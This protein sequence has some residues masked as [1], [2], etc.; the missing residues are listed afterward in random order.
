MPD[1]ASSRQDRLQLADVA[2]D[3]RL[4]EAAAQLAQARNSGGIRTIPVPAANGQPPIIMR[5]IPVHDARCELPADISAIL[6]ASAVVAKKAP[7]ADLLQALF[8]LT[9]G[10]ARVAHAVAQRQTTG[11]I[12][13]GLGLS[14]ETVRSQMKAALA[15]CGAARNIDLAAM[16]AGAVL[17]GDPDAG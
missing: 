6:I 10:E 12:A 4:S 7:G 13:A 3:V 8:G 11:A 5:L 16:L 9:R 15:K 14:Q 1:I 2:A 17:P